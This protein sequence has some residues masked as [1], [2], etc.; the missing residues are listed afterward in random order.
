MRTQDI[1]VQ[2][3]LDASVAHRTDVQCL[4]A[5]TGGRG[6]GHTHQHVLGLAVVGVKLYREAV[7]ECSG[8]TGIGLDLLFHGALNAFSA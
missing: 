7:E 8:E 5:E 2:G 1:V 3:K 6:D 4:R